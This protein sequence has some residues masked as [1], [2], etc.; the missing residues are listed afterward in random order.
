MPGSEIAI[1]LALFAYMVLGAIIFRIWRRR[2][3]QRPVDLHADP[4]AWRLAFW[5]PEL[6]AA[7]AFAFGGAA[8]ECLLIVLLTPILRGADAPYF[9]AGAVIAFI[10]VVILFVV[11]DVLFVLRARHVQRQ[12]RASDR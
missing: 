5:L 7:E 1:L 4:A 9:V 8:M 10:F 6:I 2:R 3:R 11:I 12:L